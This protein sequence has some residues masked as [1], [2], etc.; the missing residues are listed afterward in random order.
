[1]ATTDTNDLD[2]PSLKQILN[3]SDHVMDHVMGIAYQLY[4][5]GRFTEADIVCKGLIACDHRYWWPYSLHAAVLRRLGRF[6]EALAQIDEGLTYEHQQPKLLTMRME[7]L[8]T[9]SGTIAGTKPSASEMPAI[10]ASTPKR[11]DGIGDAHII[12]F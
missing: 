6:E 5:A 3:I 1:M 12:G 2:S 4:R 7:I 10:P 8:T 11:A 9:I